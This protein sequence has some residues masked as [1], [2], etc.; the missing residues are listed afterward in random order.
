MGTLFKKKL[1]GL[2]YGSTCEKVI[3]RAHCPVLAVPPL[4]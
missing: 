3:K 1:D 2:F 4:K